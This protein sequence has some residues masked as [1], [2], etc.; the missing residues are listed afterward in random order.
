M[1]KQRTAIGSLK[2]YVEFQLINNQFLGS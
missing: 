2:Y 1:K